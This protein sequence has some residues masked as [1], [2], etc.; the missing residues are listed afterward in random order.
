VKKLLYVLASSAVGLFLFTS[1][2]FAA[3]F[4]LPEQSASA[5]GM[6]SA[7]VGQADDASAVWY[8]PAGMTQLD[9]TRVMGGFV[10][11]YPTLT[12]EVPGGTTDVAERR[13]H[14]PLFLYT[15]H[16]LNDR[17]SL[18]LGI[19]NPFGLSTNWSPTST[20]REEATKSEIKATEI[21]PN[22][23]FK[24]NDKLSVAAGV[25]YVRLDA[26]LENIF[27]G[28]DFRLSGTGY[29]WGGNL[30]ALYK[31]TDQLNFG[32][33]YHSRVKIDVDGTAQMNAIGQTNPASTSITLPDLLQFGTS[34]KATDRLTLNA[35][36]G[37]TWWST[38]DTLTVHSATFIPLGSGDTIT[39]QKQWKDVWN[40][41]VGGQYKLTDEWKLRAG[42]QYDQTPVP[43]HYFETRIPDSDR[44]GASI[45][46]GYSIGNLTID[47]AYLY[48]KFLTRHIDDSVQDDGATSTNTNAL[49]G[50]YKSDAHVIALSAAYKF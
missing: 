28:Q 40:L 9:G 31:P 2:A 30:A 46:A 43:D 26:V 11:I 37:Y 27:L 48:L 38:Y 17:I 41:R 7:F 29:G 20:A 3:G 19:N 5:M 47:A 18:G 14:Y 49:N 36:I 10:A 50:T 4:A 16:Q 39:Q 15:T 42:L 8:N 12:H 44:V 33:S 21:N 22:I 23:A 24:L 34:Y 32:L 25:A 45:G 6:S 35:D 1:H 13:W